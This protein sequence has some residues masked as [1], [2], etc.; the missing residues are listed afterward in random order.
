[1]RVSI[2]VFCFLVF[3]S[4]AVNAQKKGLDIT[5]NIE[6]R[7]LG[8]KALGNNMLAKDM[9]VFYGFGLGGQL[10][11]PKNFGIGIDYNMMYSD[12]KPERKNLVGELGSQSLTNIDLIFIHKT[13]FSED[14]YLEKSG[15]F[16]F[17]R[18]KSYLH[19]S[20][21]QYTE[22]KGGFNLALK[23]VFTVDYEGYQ[24][25]VLG[26]KGNAYFSGVTNENNAVEKYYRHSYLVGLTFAYRYNF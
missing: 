15:G 14:F 26:V 8:M 21:E 10:M 19:P 24:Q 11:T 20:K 1:M 2:F 12:V 18:L 13:K 6:A 25:F 7:V 23:G 17:Y 4:S 3:T 16:S 22:G 5:S 9:G